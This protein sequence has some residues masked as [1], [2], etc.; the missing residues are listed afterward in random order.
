MR[1]W[2]GAR[3]ASFSAQ[4]PICK[5]HKPDARLP[6]IQNA[7]GLSS[8][9]VA[10]L[11]LHQMEKPLLETLSCLGAK[12]MLILWHASLVSLT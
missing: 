12:E 7:N 4:R 5:K 10:R 2:A 1:L 8:P 11:P 6:C 9:H 3:Q